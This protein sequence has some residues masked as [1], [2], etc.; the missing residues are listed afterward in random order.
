MVDIIV[1]DREK[2][3]DMGYKAFMGDVSKGS[4]RPAFCNPGGVNKMA[5]VV[6]DMKRNLDEGNVDSSQRE[7]YKINLRKHETRLSAIQDEKDNA[8]KI[9][10]GDL[11]YYQ[12][13][14]DKLAKEIKDGTHSRSDVKEKRSNTNPHTVLKDELSGMREKKLEYQ[15]LQHIMGGD[16]N[17]GYLQRK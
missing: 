8:L 10:N 16:P 14:V 9:V 5:E 2:I 17:I 7:Q 3:R 12:K 15:T 11:D 4:A 1:K 6:R 13:R